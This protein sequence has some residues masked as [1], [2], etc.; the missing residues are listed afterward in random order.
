MLAGL[1]MV[2]KDLLEIRQVDGLCCVFEK[3][4]FTSTVAII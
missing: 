2:W 1:F 4:T 3:K